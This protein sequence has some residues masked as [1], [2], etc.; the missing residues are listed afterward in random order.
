MNKCLCLVLL[1]GGVLNSLAQSHPTAARLEGEY[2]VAAYARHYNVPV[3][4]VR[5]LSL[6]F[7]TILSRSSRASTCR[8]QHSSIT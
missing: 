4:F 8:P 1:V 3:R 7:R 6:I 5:P 2:Y